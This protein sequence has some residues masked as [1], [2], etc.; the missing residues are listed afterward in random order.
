M[1]Q[2]HKTFATLKEASTWAGFSGV[3]A[4]LITQVPDN[5]KPHVAIAG[6]VCG[7]MAIMLKDNQKNNT[8]NGDD[9]G[10]SGS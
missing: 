10:K 1:L 8:E 6:G 3:S 2:F 5:Y 7:I 4:T 9:N